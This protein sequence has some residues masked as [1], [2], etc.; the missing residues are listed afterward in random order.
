M[1]ESP[2]Y[3]PPIPEETRIKYE[4]HLA[5]ILRWQDG[6][7][8]TTQE[9]TDLDHTRDM[10]RILE[11]IEKRFI[12]LPTEINFTTV[13]HMIYIHDA[14]EILAGDL[15]HS[16]PNYTDLKPKVKRRERAAFRLLSRSLEDNAIKTL[17]R[18][19]YKRVHEKSPDDKESQLTD[20]ID[21]VQAVRFGLVNV[22]PS[23]SLRNL[24][25]RRIQLNHTMAT[26]FKPADG[27]VGSLESPYSRMEAIELINEDLGNFLVQGFKKH[28]IQPYSDVVST[29]PTYGTWE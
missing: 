6:I 12:H 2:N 9:E 21:K 29:F 13:S 1:I 10:Q 5:S 25:R 26:L 14:G 7:F 15:T 11:D 28:E 24:Q 17:T 23:S 16:H 27:L 22:F 20:Y 18:D 19:L 8:T 3:R 4:K